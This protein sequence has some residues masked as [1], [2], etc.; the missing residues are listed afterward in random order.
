M[1]GRTL[2]FLSGGFLVVGGLTAIAASN[3]T[4]LYKHP[5]ARDARIIV[6]SKGARIDL[7]AIK[8]EVARETGVAGLPRAAVLVTDYDF[9]TMDPLATGTY[10]FEIKNVG[11]APLNLKLGPT[12]CKCTL[13]GLSA[14][15]LPPG[16]T[17]KIRLEWFTGRKQTR[18]EQTAVIYSNDPTQKHIA[19]GVS[20]KVRMLIGFNQEEL[21]IDRLEPDKSVT[22]EVLVYSQM[23]NDFRVTE[24]G[25]SLPGVTF[26]SE[27]VAPAYAGELE[28]LSVQRIKVTIPGT[29]PQG[30]FSDTLR[31]RIQ[32]PDAD[33]KP[34]DITLPLH[35]RVLRRLSIY[36]QG[37][38]GDGVV[39]LGTVPRGVGKRISLIVKVRDPQ[40]DL[41]IREL[42]ITPR[43]L[44]ATLQPREQDNLTGLYDLSIELP[45]G[46]EPCNYLGNPSGE[47]KIDFDHPRIDD[48]TLALHFA[49]AP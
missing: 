38:Q 28:A 39:E 35:G 48:L 43:F 23:W 19:L 13:S 10:D 31:F 42:Q 26:S 27:P 46:V 41:G 16:Q 5:Q 47:L 14:D 36:G 21:V 6:D 44:K 4:F 22:K 3:V 8:R 29:L 24:F 1:L 17:G 40:V 7:E 12:S 33:A 15:K 37:I 11:D 9:G 45:D 30:E 2:V 18:F 32:P 20:G 34:V 49:V 25:T